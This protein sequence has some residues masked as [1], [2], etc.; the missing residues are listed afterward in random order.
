MQIPAH[1]IHNVLK[2]YSKQISQT[3]LIERQK[4]L[5]QQQPSDR[6][7]ISA[8]AK[9]QSIIDKVAADIVDR[10]TRSGPQDDVDKEIVDK[11]EGEL[12]TSVSFK[13]QRDDKFV[14]NVIDGNNKK[15]TNTLEVENAGFLIKRLEQLAKE[16]VDKN[17]E[18]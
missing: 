2:V 7:H 15:T 10:I 1:Q 4:A 18:L 9:R 16:A 13:G 14:F 8:E 6:I 12:G 5:D 3:R 17:M 11:L